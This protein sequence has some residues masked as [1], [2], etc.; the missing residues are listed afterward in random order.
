[1]VSEL[2]TFPCAPAAALEAPAP[3]VVTETVVPR[4]RPGRAP[5]GDV[6]RAEKAVA[7]SSAF[8]ASP[9]EATDPVRMIDSATVRT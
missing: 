2:M 7:I 6:G 3:V 5:A 1:M 8:C 9:A 4:G